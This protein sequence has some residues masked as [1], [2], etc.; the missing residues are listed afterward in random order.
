MLCPNCGKEVTRCRSG[1]LP[2][3]KALGRHTYCI[4]GTPR[5]DGLSPEDRIDA[6]ILAA[7]RALPSDRRAMIL[8][9]VRLLPK[10]GR[11]GE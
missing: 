10:S 3:H 7:L 5:S 1:H 9:E 6:A 11:G 2:A 8:R 4:A